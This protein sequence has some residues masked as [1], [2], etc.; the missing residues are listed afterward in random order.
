MDVQVGDAEA[1]AVLLQQANGIGIPLQG[2]HRPLGHEPGNFQRQCS[3]APA[4]IPHQR[5]GPGPQVGQQ[6]HPQLH[7]GG[8]EA[9]GMLKR[10]IGQA[11]GHEIPL[12]GPGLLHQLYVAT[13][14]T[15]SAIWPGH[16]AC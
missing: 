9:R 13:T 8:A 15:V 14:I 3:G 10:P 1:L 5:I 2:V 16:S 12:V 7:G 4:H 6:H 11:R